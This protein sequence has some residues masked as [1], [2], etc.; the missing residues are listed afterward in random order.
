MF[1]VYGKKNIKTMDTCVGSGAGL[2]RKGNEETFL[3]MLIFHILMEI[4]LQLYTF[5]KIH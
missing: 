1:I 5:V 2:T 4:G 3:G